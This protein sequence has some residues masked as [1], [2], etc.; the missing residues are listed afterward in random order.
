M[1]GIK[2]LFNNAKI[3]HI[4]SVDDCY[5]SQSELRI[6]NLIYECQQNKDKF[7][8][9]CISKHMDSVASNVKE[10]NNSYLNSV[11]NSLSEQQKVDL[12]TFLHVENVEKS[13]IIAFC[14][15]LK[16]KGV[17]ESYRTI[18]SIEDATKEY[19]KINVNSESRALWLID[20]DFCNS[21]GSS[22]DGEK[23]IKYLVDDYREGH[24]F[25]L[26]SAQGSLSDNNAEFRR[27]LNLGNSKSL[28]VCQI[29]KKNILEKEFPEIY[30]EMY[31]GFRENFSGVLVDKLSKIAEK[32]MQKS[33]TSISDLGDDAVRKVIVLG[34][35]ED[36]ISPIETFQRLI[37]IILKSDFV[38]HIGE[39]YDEIAKIVYDYGELC[40]YGNGQQEVASDYQFIE[41][42]RNLELYDYRVNSNYNPVSSGDV[43]RINEKEYVLLVQACNVTIRKDG[44]RKSKCATLAEIVKSTNDTRSYAFYSLDNF[45][46]NTEKAI[47]FNSTINVDYDVLDLCSLNQNGELLLLDE[48]DIERCKF[49]YSD[50]Y[51]ASIKSVIEKNRKLKDDYE[52]LRDNKAK[53]NIDKLLEKARNIYKDNNMDIKI[54]F[55]NGIKYNGA[56]IARINHDIMDDISKTYSEYHS[57]KALDF[58]FS[59][60]Y[61]TKVYEVK[62]EFDFEKYNINKENIEYP[63]SFTYNVREKGDAKL[64]QK[65]ANSFTSQYR[66]IF[67]EG[68]QVEIA[69]SQ[70]SNDSILIKNKYTPVLIGNQ[71]YGNVIEVV[72]GFLQLKIEKPLL[73]DWISCKNNSFKDP[74]NDINDRSEMK[75]SNRY[76]I[77]KFKSD[78]DYS[79]YN[80]GISE[81][82]L[83]FAFKEFANKVQ[84]CI[85]YE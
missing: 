83:K 41:N 56:R 11:V 28:L 65:V 50:G 26:S 52:E 64:N 74:Y 20:N 32:A 3:K 29:K 31:W 1:I 61:K 48:Y 59:A 37:M 15:E 19:D 35:S 6:E 81:K 79:F 14:E 72:N 18:A 46:G 58:D 70:V 34:S 36:G 33:I 42:L 24:I 12:Q 57:R 67:K 77:I 4:I 62:Y 30:K 25:A 51:L 53:L 10:K 8:S 49:R 44:S 66:N 84:L 76:V 71:I 13:K 69:K 38:E 9:F 75:I 80:A 17:I 82:T 16:S 2:E 23:F 55:E 63:F 47:S 54:A 73:D 5:S 21:G 60:G 22:C 78:E 39:K 7:I 27:K 40:K 43:F 45:N 68:D 85:N